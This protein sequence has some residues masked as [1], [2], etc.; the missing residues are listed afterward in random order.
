MQNVTTLNVVLL[1]V[2][3]LSVVA[4]TKVN[5][6]ER[7]TFFESE[8]KFFFVQQFFGAGV[9]FYTNFKL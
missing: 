3:I 4:Q 7:K 5:Q 2:V 1:N 6:G 8:K 9:E